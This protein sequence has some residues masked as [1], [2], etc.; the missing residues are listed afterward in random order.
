M[1]MGKG[2]GSRQ[3]VRRQTQGLGILPTSFIRHLSILCEFAS[4]MLFGL[5]SRDFNCG[6]THTQPLNDNCFI[7]VQP[8]VWCLA[9]RRHVWVDGIEE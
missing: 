4:K 1:G 3:K 9:V 2:S 6:P 5:R 7:S 8:Q